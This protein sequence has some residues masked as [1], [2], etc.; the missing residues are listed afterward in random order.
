MSQP[1]FPSIL[2]INLPHTTDRLLEIT[3]EME[4]WKSGIQ[5]EILEGITEKPGWKG[6]GKS[7]L[8]AIQLAKERQYPWV[9]ILEDDCKFAANSFQQFETLL[10]I[11]WDKKEGWDVF[12]G[13][14]VITGRVQKITDYPPIFQAEALTTHFTLIHSGSYKKILSYDISCPYDFFLR[15]QCRLWMTLPFLATQRVSYSDIDDR[16]ISYDICLING[17]KQLESHL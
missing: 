7:H 9:L 12:L 1:N 2:I 11:L 13:G 3:E 14:A 17:E 4:K 8:K 16:I 15:V 6:C 10:P 5:Y